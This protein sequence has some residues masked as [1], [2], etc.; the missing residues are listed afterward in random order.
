[1]ISLSKTHGE[2]KI[3]ETTKLALGILILEGK[4]REVLKNGLKW[5]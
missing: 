5:L 2:E 4:L 3:V 1:M